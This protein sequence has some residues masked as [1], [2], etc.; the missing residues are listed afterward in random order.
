MREYLRINPRILIRQFV[1]VNCNDELATLYAIHSV[2]REHL[3]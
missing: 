3:L 1:I 2:N